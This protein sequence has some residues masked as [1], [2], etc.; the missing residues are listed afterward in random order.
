[1]HFQ[2]RSQKDH[3]T[4]TEQ[5]MPNPDNPGLWLTYTKCDPFDVDD[6]NDLAWF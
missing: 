1:M 4:L 6:S 3:N 5:L 2:G